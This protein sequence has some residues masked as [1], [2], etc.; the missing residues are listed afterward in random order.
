MS[1]KSAAAAPTKMSKSPGAERSASRSPQLG[2]GQS[3]PNAA[4]WRWSPW[5]CA[6]LVFGLLI[7]LGL[8]PGVWAGNGTDLYS[9]MVPM[10]DAVQRLGWLPGWNPGPLGGTPA[11][12]ALQLGLLYPPNWLLRPFDAAHALEWSVWAHVAWLAGGGVFLSRQLAPEA[13]GALHLIGALLWAGSGPLW[14]HVWAGHVSWVQA[15]AWLPWGLGLAVAALRTAQVRTIVLCALA[16]AVQLLAG[17]PQVSFLGAVGGVAALLLLVPAGQ[18]GGGLGRRPL[19]WLAALLAVALAVLLAA[20][21]LWPTAALAPHLNRALSSPREIALAFESQ[22]QTLLT[23]LAPHAG[24]GPAASLTNWGSYHESLAFVGA[25]AAGLAAMGALGLGMGGAAAVFWLVLCAVLAAGSHGGLLP[26][27]AD[28]A[29]G[30]GAFRVPSRWMLAAWP[31]LAVLCSA[32]LHAQ[33]RSGSVRKPGA[34]VAGGLAVAL[35]VL[36][37]GWSAEHPLLAASLSKDAAPAA[38]AEALSQTRMALLTGAAALLVAMAVGLLPH[39]GRLAAMSLAL[40]ALGQSL[41]FV[42]LHVQ[43]PPAKT[44]PAQAFH[45]DDATAAALRQAAAN[46]QHRVAT[47]APLRHANRP[48][49]VGL[50]GA[51]AY[52][53]ALTLQANRYGNLLGSRPVGQYAVNHQV[54]G[55]SAWLDRI[56]TGVFVRA[57]SDQRS[58]AAFADWPVVQTLA[59]AGGA[60]VVHKHPQPFARISAAAQLVVEPDPV[61]ALQ[62]LPELGRDTVVVDRDLPRPSGPAPVLTVRTDQPEQI[63][64]DVVASGPAV[65]VVRDALA[66]GWTATV[67]GQPQPIALADGLFRAIAVP[68]GRHAL[69]L[70]FAVPGL[71]EG[72]WVSAAALLA[73]LLL[74]LAGSRQSAQ[75]PR[76]N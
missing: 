50:G 49:A 2:G 47:A 5:L 23:F 56:A 25:G 71:R 72:L 3:G 51:G 8:A 4:L 59:D 60:L 12:A 35:L 38:L 69:Q 28:A 53:P 62:R 68:A 65:V 17:H 55:P 46:G 1:K 6:A 57:A 70:R 52:E 67:D 13:P 42:S 30:F 41:W 44:M 11:H 16:L 40:M 64:I 37:L 14:G 43:T 75:K 22:P 20:A 31:V 29:P 9:Y 27:L 76:A 18:A 66:P 26:A 54:R 21:Q 24:G 15:L 34:L 19:G 32:G 73:L 58:A 7:P 61:R 63:D 33:L 48:A 39:A 10:R 74:W 36:G 45:W